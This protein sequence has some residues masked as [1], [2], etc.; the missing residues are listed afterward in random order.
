MYEIEDARRTIDAQHVPPERSAAEG[1]HDPVGVVACPAVDVRQPDDARTQ[2]GLAR[3]RGQ[4][5]GLCL[6]AS[7]AIE[8]A[9]WCVL[10]DGKLAGLAVD[11]TAAGQEHPGTWIHLYCATQQRARA[12]DVGAGTEAGSIL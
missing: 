3:L 4:G 2:T 11:L 12:F 6:A 1:W 9:Q 8:G 5:L 7:I 10:P